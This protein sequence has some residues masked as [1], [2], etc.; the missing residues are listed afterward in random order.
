MTSSSLSFGY[1]PKPLQIEVG[2]IKIKSNPAL[3][4][5]V[6]AVEGDDRIDDGWIYAPPQQRKHL[7]G[8]IKQKP[9][10]TRVFGLPKTHTISHAS[11]DCEEHLTFHIWCLSFFT[12]MRL[13]SSEAGFLD[14]TPINHG[15]LV[16]FVLLDDGLASGV[17]LAEAFW[18][19]H[20]TTPKY[21]KLIEAAI[22]S[23]FLSQNPQSLQFE[24]FLMLYAA[25][26]ACYALAE[27][28]LPPP[29]SEN[30]AGRVKWMCD[31]FEIPIPDW[32][33]IKQK[34]SALSILRND[35]IH[36]ALFVRAPLG[37]ALH[38]IDTNQNLTLEMEA[39]V[40]RLLVA[41]IGSKA[42]YVRTPVTDRQRHGLRII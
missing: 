8:S 27:K 1:Y 4:D 28:I 11:S 2:S 5:T 29:K 40:C 24:S 33:I 18:S 9:Y 30:H 25:F 14:C 7:V 32:G 39:L 26:D 16:D 31:R 41:L 17:A 37:F 23:L 36:E 15:K 13:T 12:G 35:A 21:S 20:K 34:Q 22:H 6:A 38:G 42:D 10:S 19:R 3:E